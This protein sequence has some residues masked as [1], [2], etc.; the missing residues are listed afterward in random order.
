[1]ITSR[2]VC[3]GTRLKD[4]V[5][6]GVSSLREINQ[7]WTCAERRLDLYSNAPLTSIRGLPNSPKHVFV[8]DA[9]RLISHTNGWSP[10]SYFFPLLLEPNT[11]PWSTRCPLV[12]PSSYEGDGAKIISSVERD[13]NI[14]DD[15]LPSYH[16]LHACESSSRI[17]A[18]TKTR[19]H[20]H[21]SQESIEC[22]SACRP[23]Q[24]EHRVCIQ[25]CSFTSTLMIISKVVCDN[26]CSK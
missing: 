17:P 22:S 13:A 20:A 3:D 7:M 6:Q 25:C 1:M 14:G 11:P 16:H 5:G 23:R 12:A 19:H 10:A 9:D 26:T 24:V 15:V 18:H 4:I 8:K 21:L 2:A